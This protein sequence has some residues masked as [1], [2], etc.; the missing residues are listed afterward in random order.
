MHIAYEEVM[1]A[2]VENVKDKLEKEPEGELAAWQHAYM[3]QVEALLR[4]IKACRE[5]NHEEY[6][7][8]LS[9]QVKYIFQFDPYK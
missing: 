9:D 6:L 7:A 2:Y 1:A 3:Q 5:S 8:S 4:I